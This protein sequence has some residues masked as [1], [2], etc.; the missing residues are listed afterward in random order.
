MAHL[1]VV[2]T[3]KARPG[4]ERE[5]LSMLQG[6]VGPTRAEEGCL[7]YDLH[8]S[9]DEPDTFL[10][11]ETWESRPLWDAHMASPHLVAFGEANG[12]VTESWTLFAGHRLDGDT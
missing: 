3:L 9:D 12:A 7:R 5:L 8:R 11:H 10:F 1:T 6:L 2:A 4:Q